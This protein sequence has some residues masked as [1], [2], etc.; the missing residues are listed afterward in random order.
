MRKASKII[1]IVLAI[2]FVIGFYYYHKLGGFNEPEITVAE[3]PGYVVVGKPYQGKM[4][5]KELGNLFEEA[6]TYLEKKTLR[7]TSAGVFYSN[8]EKENDTI[9]AFV[10][11]ILSDTS[12][13]LPQGYEKR[14]IPA[15]KILRAH[16]KS[17]LLVA[18]FI[19]PKL[20]EQA[21]LKKVELLHVPSIEMYPSDMEMIIE[22]PV[23]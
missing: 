12:Q 3:A 20:E 1:L 23:K 18:P 10:G 2:L 17:H 6:E 5:S 8:P 13:A 15:R 22:V 16:I 7:G 19:Y 14:S 9:K 21:K 4:T 11:V